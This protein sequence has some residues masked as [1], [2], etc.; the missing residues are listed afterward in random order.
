MDAALKKLSIFCL[1]NQIIKLF[2]ILNKKNDCLIF[3]KKKH[4]L[5]SKCHP[6]GQNLLK[7]EHI[8]LHGPKLCLLANLPFLLQN[9][10]GWTVCYCFISITKRAIKTCDISYFSP[11]NCIVPIIFLMNLQDFFF[12]VWKVQSTFF[13]LCLKSIIK[14]F[15]YS[16]I[17]L[18]F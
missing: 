7:R 3:I 10:P 12:L 1:G 14:K 2:W 5:V 13:R 11:K 4:S 6:E 9:R 15:Y 17:P 8:D 18:F 16:Y